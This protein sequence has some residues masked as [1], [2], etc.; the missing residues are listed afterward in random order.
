MAITEDDYNK[1]IVKV[2]EIMCKHPSCLENRERFA[3]LQRDPEFKTENYKIFVDTSFY[4]IEA[5]EHA[6]KLEIENLN[7]YL[8]KLQKFVE[9][10]KTRPISAW[11]FSDKTEDLKEGLDLKFRGLGIFETIK[12]FPWT[13][14]EEVKSEFDEIR[15]RQQHITLRPI[16][17]ATNFKIKALRDANW[18]WEEVQSFLRETKTDSDKK[19]ELEIEK[20]TAEL[21]KAGKREAEIDKILDREFPPQKYDESIDREPDCDSIRKKRKAADDLCERFL[22]FLKI[23]K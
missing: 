10:W 3:N 5:P 12:V 11:L 19:I 1:F 23:G 16:V 9:K 14:K 18:K 2:D 22:D 8:F 7:A 6:D 15:K 13:T 21:E 20:R 4:L 17:Y